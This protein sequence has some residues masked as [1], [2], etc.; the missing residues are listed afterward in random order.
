MYHDVKVGKEVILH[1][2][3]VLGSD[4]FGLAKDKG[5]WLKIAQIGGV[6]IGNNV[7]IG[8]NTVVDRGAMSDTV[9]E[10]NVKLD[11]LIQIAHNVHVGKNTAIAGCTAVAGPPGPWGRSCPGCWDS[12]R[13]HRS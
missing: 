1:S 4:G 10:D 9:I 7:E 3:V 2:G 12:G 6:A 8:A 5:E 13:C 11:N